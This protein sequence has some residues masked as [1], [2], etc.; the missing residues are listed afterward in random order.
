[1]GINLENLVRMLLE[2]CFLLLVCFEFTS[3]LQA[4]SIKICD[5][6]A[7]VIMG[8]F[9]SRISDLLRGCEAKLR[10]ICSAFEIKTMLSAG[11]LDT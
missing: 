7:V 3:R 1:M 2:L 8:K 5:D 10:G 4:W 11:Y 9:Y 6:A